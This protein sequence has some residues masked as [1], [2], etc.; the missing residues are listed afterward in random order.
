MLSPGPSAG[1]FV[2][3]VRLPLAGPYRPL[4]SLY[5]G[6]DGVLRWHLRVWHVDRPV[7]HWFPTEALRAFAEINRL[8]RVAVEID[9]LVACALTRRVR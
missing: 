5:V 1:R 9:R 4:A 7:A 8:D 2:G 6:A 3:A